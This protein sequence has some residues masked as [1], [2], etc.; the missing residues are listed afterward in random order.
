M[1]KPG[2]FVRFTYRFHTGATPD[3]PKDD[4]KEVLVLHPGWK[5]RM[6]GIDLK[7]L[8][9]AERAVLTLIFDPKSKG[10]QHNIPL[11][12]D[13]LRRMDPVEDVKNPVSFY[14]KFVKVFIRDKDVY[15][16]YYTS[17]MRGISV[18]RK[19]RVEGN[20]INP[21]PLFKPAIT[22]NPSGAS[23]PFKPTKINPPPGRLEL[24]KQRHELM[25]QRL[26]QQKKGK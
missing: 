25:K 22:K 20:V 21:K 12:D 4:Y 9:A 2:A 13:I 8:T 15:R 3:E 16:T 23:S 5:N 26:A 24:L 14:T 11:V 19:S 1:L 10:K 7:R 17:W 6:H 18:I